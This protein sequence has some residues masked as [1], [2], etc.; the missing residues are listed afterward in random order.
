MIETSLDVTTNSE[1]AVTESQSAQQLQVMTMK[2]R[3]MISQY[4]KNMKRSNEAYKKAV[5]EV[6]Q[7]EVR[8]FKVLKGQVGKESYKAA[9]LSATV[10]TTGEDGVVT[11]SVDKSKLLRLLNLEIETNRLARVIA[12]KR[13]K[14]TGSKTQ[15]AAIRGFKALMQGK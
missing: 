1:E 9:K 8:M 7:R 5:S 10:S 11:T 3:K 14:T 12:G 4:Q 2:M 15:R 13:K 6:N